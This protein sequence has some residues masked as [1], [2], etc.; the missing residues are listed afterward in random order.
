M[1]EIDYDKALSLVKAEIDKEGVDHVYV[2]PY[3]D[4]CHNVILVDDE[5][6]GSCLIGR[7]LVVAG[8]NAEAL[9]IRAAQKDVSDT[10]LSFED[11]LHLTDKAETFLSLVQSKQDIGWPWLDALEHALNE[12][13]EEGPRYKENE[14]F[15]Y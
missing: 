13:T 11:E 15:R 5:Y 2:Q 7:C 12:M 4:G 1:I 3:D 14:S 6:V 8:L 9:F 10:A